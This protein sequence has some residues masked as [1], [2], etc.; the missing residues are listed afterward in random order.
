MNIKNQADPAPNESTLN[1]AMHTQH[2]DTLVNDVKTIGTP[3]MDSTGSTPKGNSGAVGSEKPIFEGTLHEKMIG[4]K[5][6]N[7]VD[8]H[9]G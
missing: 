5:E 8:F 7:K 4:G 1:A 6:G 3:H 9:K 2:T